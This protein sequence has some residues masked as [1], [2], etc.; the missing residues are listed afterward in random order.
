MAIEKQSPVISTVDQPTTIEE[1]EIQEIVDLKTPDGE[2]GFEILEDGSA[3]PEEDLVIPE[4]VGFDGNLAE[5][6]EEDDLQK[7]S[8]DIV[9]GIESDKASRKDWEKTYTDGLK[10]LGMRF[11]ED[12]SEPFEG[13]SGV[14]HPLL[15]E[16]VTSFQ[17]QAYKELLPAGGPVKT[18]V[19]GD[20]D[21]NIEM[22]AQR[23]KEFMNYQIVHKMEEYDQ[24][25]DQL[26]FYLPLAGSAFKKIYYDDTLG[27]AVSKFVAPEDLIVPYYTT[28]IESASRITNVVKMSENEV[29]KLQALGFYREVAIQ[30][31]DDQDQ[32]GQVDDEIEKLTGMRKGY[33]GDEV[34]VLYEVHTSLDLPGFEDAS[35]DGE[36]SGVK[37]PYIITIDSNSNEV[38]SIRRNYQENDPLRKK[39]EYFVHFKFLPGLGFYGFGLTHMIGGLSKASTSIM[40]QLIDAGTL[41]NL[42]AGF[43]TRGIRIRD[44]DTPIQPGEFRDVDAPGGSLRE[45]IQPLPFKE[46]SG[47][48][49]NL[50]NILVDSGKTFAS[51]AEINTGQG[52]PQAPVGTTMALLERSTKVL[53]AIHKRLHNAQRKEFKILASVF[54]DYLP[55]E[56]PY[57]TA[58]GNL[59]I[60]TQDFDDKVDII[61]VS[62]PDIFSTA[63]RIAMAQEMMNL[64]QSNPTIHGPDGIYESYRRMYAAIGVDNIDQILI[65]PPPTE[66]QP[67]EAG[68]ENNTLIM[69]QPAKAFPQQNHDAHIAAHMGLL[70]TPP[71]Q[72]NAQ[73]QATIHAHVM[74]HLQMKADILALQQM[75]PEL[76]AQYDSINQQLQQADPQ[77][78]MGLQAES[79]NLLAQFSSPIL[80]ELV[81]DYTSRVG[82]PEDEDPL[83]SIRK[84]ELALRGAELQQEQQQFAVDQQ[85]RSEEALR[86]DQIDREQIESR[87]QIAKMKDDTSKQRMEIQKQL[88]IQDLINKYNK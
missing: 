19:L 13:A 60:K 22:Q 64:V 17:A 61:P 14:I 34:V 74:E 49:L 7:I 24:E 51:I 68:S 6:I 86:N 53:S 44:E 37:L 82:S 54:K 81:N 28:D 9:A 41:A 26:L 56:Y 42:P 12:R 55:Q 67:I 4:D 88:K 63:Q 87:E 71:V 1:K 40:R 11:D 65:P 69:G 80:A 33:D 20:Y 15:G 79:Q 58:Q 62:N 76:K 47:T 10:F 36:P 25:L 77:Q 18:Q 31:G 52:N 59:Q 21:S 75:P 32:Y 29:K 48:L 85:R 50:L 38:L 30:T 23:V 16:A 43:K 46:P 83:V 8:S 5:V 3:V 27:R 39:I 78:A 2:Q 70:N 66:P 73:V 57:M 45:S 84:Q 72:S 35:L